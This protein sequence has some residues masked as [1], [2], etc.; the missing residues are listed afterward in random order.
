MGEARVTTV[1]RHVGLADVGPD[2]R[3]R[4]DALARIVQD[5]SDGDASSVD[6]DGM[7]LW[8]LR[9]MDMEITATPRFRADVTGSTWCSGIGARWAER[10]TQLRV[11]DALCVEATG[12]WVHTDPRSGAPTPLPPG[13][14]DVWGATADGRKV[15]A[16]LRHAPPPPAAARR[17]WALRVTDLDV[18]GHVNN[19]AYWEAIEDE[20]VRRG[21][22]RV[23]RAEIEFR[24]GLDLTDAVDLVIADT[25]DGFAAWLCVDG[26]V[27]ASALVGCEPCSTT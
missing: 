7:G 24:A 17:P 14:D 5:V 21:R 18:V 9:R 8:I 22:P 6:I 16:R 10:T 12:I 2:A 26:D 11:G 25:S 27:R 4:L 19:A 1:E 20:L 3:A 23:R 13:F 15:S